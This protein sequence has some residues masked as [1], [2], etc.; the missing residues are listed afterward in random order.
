MRP[1][2]VLYCA[3]WTGVCLRGTWII[4]SVSV[5]F[6]IRMGFASATEQMVDALSVGMRGDPSK[7][8]EEVQ[9]I[10]NFV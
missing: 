3:A 6:S 4:A 10:E 2:C 5:C 7:L 8:P 9:P 1:S